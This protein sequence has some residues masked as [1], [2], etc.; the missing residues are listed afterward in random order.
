MSQPSDAATGSPLI[1]SA[2]NVPQINLDVPLPGEVEPAV[3]KR[4]ASKKAPLVAPQ[5]AED[6]P[7]K[8]VS[9]AKYV[10]YFS[11]LAKEIPIG[12]LRPGLREHGQT[13][14]LD[15]KF[16]AQLRET[17]DV[18]QPTAPVQVRVWDARGVASH[19]M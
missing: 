15:V 17:L 19:F 14:R 8:W 5:P 18:S 16:V 9:T 6:T 7:D 3:A 13:R 12:D 1:P 10:H 11:D 4:V 2:A